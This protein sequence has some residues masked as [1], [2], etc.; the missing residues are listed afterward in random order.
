[1][2]NTKSHFSEVASQYRRLRTT[3]LKPVLFIKKKLQKY[4]NIIAADIGCGAG[5]YDL[6]LFQNLNKKL[7][8]YCFDNN[9]E[10]I[11]ELT[12]FLKENNIKNFKAKK[13][14]AVKI[15]LPDNSLD[16]LFTFNA[17]HHFKILKFLNN[18]SRILKKNGYLFIYTRLRSQN[19]KNIWGNY[20]PLFNQKENRL[21]ELNELKNLFKKYPDL[22]IELIKTFKYKRTADLNLLVSRAE[23]HHYSTFCLY[24]K[25]EFK[26]SLNKFIRRIKTHFKDLKNII[27]ID[28]NTLLVIRKI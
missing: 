6:K 7:F 16:C 25:G 26:L 9:K 12:I 27:W 21:Y 10:M 20:F 1:M 3:D 5:R 18:A 24:K 2:K 23:N 4:S 17:I 11:K 15:P 14:S 22:K 28:E 13:A 19:R 8:L